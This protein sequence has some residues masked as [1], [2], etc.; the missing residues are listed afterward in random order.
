MRENQLRKGE[1]QMGECSVWC[2]GCLIC[3]PL[4]GAGERLRGDRRG[5]EEEEDEE[6]KTTR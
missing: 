2:S 4:C 5:R 6:N 1:Y 3:L